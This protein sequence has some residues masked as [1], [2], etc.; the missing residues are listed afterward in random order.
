M[1]QLVGVQKLGCQ[2]TLVGVHSVYGVC[3][4]FQFKQLRCLIAQ[5]ATSDRRWKSQHSSGFPGF[6]HATAAERWRIDRRSGYS[7]ARLTSSARDP[8]VLAC[9]SCQLFR[10]LPSFGRSRARQ[11]LRGCPRPVAGR[12]NSDLVAM[13]AIRYRN[14]LRASPHS[15]RT[16]L[17]RAIEYV[18][19]YLYTYLYIHMLYDMKY[20][21][22][23]PW[24][25][26]RGEDY[27]Y[28]QER[29]CL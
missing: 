29:L 26:F 15:P 13:I 20:L 12:G 23:V 7:F 28:L 5:S 11:V 27:L 14:C 1:H 24:S 10:S 16:Y 18:Y 6:G 9:S 19:I 21:P 17:R 22:L 25:K 4:I 2:T 8:T 3:P